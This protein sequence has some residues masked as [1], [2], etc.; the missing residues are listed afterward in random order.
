MTGQRSQKSSGYRERNS[1]A[2]RALDI[3]QLFDDDRLVVGGQEVADALGVARSTAYRYLQSL[4]AAGFIEEHRPA[5]YRLGPRVFELARLARKGLGL[6]EIARP[7]M[8]ELVEEVGETVLLTRRAGAS[9]VCLEREETGHPVR[10]SYERGH[11]LPINAGASALVLLA[12]ATD[13]EVADVVAKHGLPRFTGATVTDE[14]VLRERL[15]RIRT[16]DAAVTRGELDADVLGVAAPIRD[17]DGAVVAAV[18]IAALSHRVPEERVPEVVA[19][20]RRTAG[21]ITDRLAVL[22]S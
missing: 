15:A 7:L 14:G 1:T 16:D 18:S 20:V 3:L 11:V 2:E 10:L 19:A 13:E 17:V 8:R 6:S 4:S 9:V 21:R 22:A 5:G 12:W